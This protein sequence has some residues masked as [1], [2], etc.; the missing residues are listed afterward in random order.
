MSG[1]G[2]SRRSFLYGAGAAGAGLGLSGLLAACGGD[3]AASPT[4]VGGSPA[5]SGAA[6]P[7]T[8]AGRPTGTISL[9]SYFSEPQ[10]EAGQQAIIDAFMAGGGGEVSLNTIEGGTFRTQI[11]SYLTAAEPPDV[12]TWFAGEATRDF[13]AE[14]LL[15]DLS[16]VWDEIAP[17][18]PEA[19]RI[20][21]TADDGTQVFIPT[22]YQ[23]WAVFYRPSKF[24]EWGVEPPTTFDE[25]K[26]VCAAID[27]QGVPPIGIGL[28][29][30]PWMASA[31]F[32][33]FNMR[34]NGPQFHLDVLAGRERFDDP[35][36]RAAFDPWTEILPYFDPNGAGLAFQEAIT[37][38][39]QG[40]TGMYL[41]GAF[42]ADSVPAEAIDDLDFFQFPI[43]DPSVPVGEEGPLDGYM[44]SVNSGNV[45]VTKDFMRFLASVEAQNIFIENSAGSTIPAHPDAIARD[46]PLIKKGKALLESAD[47]LSQFF[48]RDATDALQPT[49]DTALL[50]FMDNPD[51]IDDILTTWQEQ[52]EAAR[53]A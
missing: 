32:D 40:N 22:N 16:D 26:E 39:T 15:L 6:S 48:N 52:A 27:G 24:A 47:Q 46:T 28:S 7:T 51:Q 8:A 3:D 33:Y 17:E 11:P 38:M 13:A 29:N 45:E 19:M 18:Y 2:I 5:T 14:G 25:F 43:I 12:Y 53:Q 10:G 50:R 37:E 49:A 34:V 42:L 9:Q 1:S 36:V 23:W 4:T 21:C 44:A 41:C 35:R 31:W 20:L 30:T